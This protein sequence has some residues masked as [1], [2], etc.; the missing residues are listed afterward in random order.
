VGLV[1]LGSVKYGDRSAA[2][3]AALAFACFVSVACEK[4]D[5]GELDSGMAAGDAPLADSGP[6]DSGRHDAGISS[7][8]DFLD[9]PGNIPGCTDTTM[10]LCGTYKMCVNGVCRVHRDSNCPDAGPP[11]VDAGPPRPDAMPHPDAA[12]PPDSGIHPCQ[13]A[14]DCSGSGDSVQM[15]SDATFSCVDSRCLW[16]CETERTC[17]SDVRKMCIQC[18]DTAIEAC[19]SNGVCLDRF[20]MAR[21]EESTCATFPNSTTPLLN[22]VLT[23]V[24]TST[25]GCTYNAYRS[26]GAG[27]LGDFAFLNN[28]RLMANIPGFGGA[29]TGTYAPTG[30]LRVIM[31]CRTCMFVMS[32]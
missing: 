2:A 9:C 31:S 30:A 4:A 20:A 21:V 14:A 29:C 10:C 5:V 24:R 22:A 15:C 27:N 25:E 6:R 11:P 28:G 26:S 13:S 17:T 23:V 32:F 1:S 16:A 19:P 7:C 12:P 3:C 18:D 8:V